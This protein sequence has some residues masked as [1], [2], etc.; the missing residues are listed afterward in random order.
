MP[1]SQNLASL[2]VLESASTN[3]GPKPGSSPNRPAGH[4]SASLRFCTTYRGNSAILRDDSLWRRGTRFAAR[5]AEKA[6]VGPKGSGLAGLTRVSPARHLA[7]NRCAAR[8]TGCGVRR[9]RRIVGHRLVSRTFSR[10]PVPL[11][12][13]IL[14]GASRRRR[15][16]IFEPE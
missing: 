9:R 8:W 5:R 10:F 7:A 15:L 2:R 3:A 16:S 12:S 14:R 1:T 11:E 6:R 4:R 13:V